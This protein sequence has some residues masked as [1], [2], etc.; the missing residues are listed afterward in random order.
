[1]GPRAGSMSA[2]PIPD[3]DSV[4]DRPHDWF[5]RAILRACA[6]RSSS[7]HASRSP[8]VALYSSHLG[9]IVTDQALMVMP[10]HEQFGQAVYATCT[11]SDGEV[12]GM[13]VERML[14]EARAA[15]IDAEAWSADRVRAAIL[16]VVAASRKKE[17]V[18]VRFWLNSG[19]GF[20]KKSQEGHATTHSTSFYA[21]VL[22]PSS[23]ACSDD[24]ALERGTAGIVSS[25]SPAPTVA[26]A[27][28][29]AP[30]DLYEGTTLA[31]AL[32]RL[33]SRLLARPS[34][35]V[36][37]WHNRLHAKLLAQSQQYMA[38]SVP[39]QTCVLSGIGVVG[40]VVCGAIVRLITGCSRKGK[41]PLSELKA[42]ASYDDWNN[43]WASES[44][45]PS[46]Y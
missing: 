26:L 20:L 22:S 16:A 2:M 23:G 14:Q 39:A 25:S 34:C 37:S 27:R 40:L 21:M 44:G 17:N 30:Y 18:A 38:L 9:G 3:D 45:Y 10:A 4:H 42:R 15:G 28:E 6:N 1:M 11:V 46:M 32:P 12:C 7:G 13:D 35:Y 19:M 33:L 24:K 8:M 31:R 36:R 41:V 43:A 5:L 29:R